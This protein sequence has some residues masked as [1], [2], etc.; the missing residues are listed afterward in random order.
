AHDRGPEPFEQLVLGQARDLGEQLV[1]DATPGD[2]SD[3]KDRGRGFGDR[4]DMRQENLAQGWW[5][6]R[7]RRALPARSEQLLGEEG[8]AVRT[9]E[10]LADELRVRLRAE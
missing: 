10:H 5:K 4:G 6:A 1:L 3:A 2:R 9:A 8:V 7:T